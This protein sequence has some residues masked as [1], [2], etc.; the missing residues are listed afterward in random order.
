MSKTVSLDTLRGVATAA[1][2]AANTSDENARIV[3]EALVAADAD[4]LSSHGVSRIPFYADQSASGKVDGH[5]VPELRVVAQACVRVDARD[6]FAFPAMRAGLDAATELLG[7]AG[8]AAVA[9]SNSHHAGAGGYHVEHVARQGYLALGFSNT[10]SGMAPWGGFKGTFGTNPI[11]FA[12]PR[13]NNPPLVIDLS[14]SKVAR[15]KVML[16]E[17]SGEAIPPDWAL[18]AQGQ[19]TAD[20]KAALAGTMVPIGEAKG[21]ALAL[22][23]EILAAGLTGSHFAFQASSFFTANGPPPRIGQFFVLFNPAVCAGDGFASRIEE[24]IA[25]IL[26]QDG[27]RLPGDRRLAQ[28]EKSLRKGVVLP[29][30][31][32]DELV[33]RAG[34]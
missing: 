9:I 6:G 33:R 1:L 28:R 16:A 18:D 32:Y 23:V 27:A 26:S 8:T 20:P 22:M 29:D 4:G 14:L 11:F 12:C 5:A 17:K 21:A 31:L 15:G 10:P 19:P 25:E 3:A 13:E 2:V 24:L 30:Q 7:H 34:Q